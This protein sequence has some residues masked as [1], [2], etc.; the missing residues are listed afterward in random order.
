MKL[1]K[2]LISTL[3]VF[4]VLTVGLAA[5]SQNQPL[6]DYARR[7]KKTTPAPKVKPASHVYDNDNLPRETTLS[8]V[9]NESSETD[10]GGEHEK[11]KDATEAGEKTKDAADATKSAEASK[12]E[13]SETPKSETKAGEKEEGKPE[14]QLKEGQSSEERDK[15]VEA[16]EKK[17]DSE[18]DKVALASRELDVLQR[19][20]Q[21]KVSEFYSD[22][23][24]RVQNPNGLADVDSQYK[25]QIAD[26]QKQLDDAKS[27]LSDTQEEGR[28]AGAPNSAVD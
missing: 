26:K 13:S 6:G 28:R 24:R 14:A 22:T 3:A 23:A 19:E 21:L 18:K 8:I 16:L 4:C 1:T 15:A 5:Q 10:S 20:Y 11:A 9:G 17:L 25:E 2:Y 12:S 7:V 27:E